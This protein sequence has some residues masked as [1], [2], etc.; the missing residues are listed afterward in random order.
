MTN[1]ELWQEASAANREC[2]DGKLSLSDMLAIIHD[3][4]VKMNENTSR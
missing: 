1:S 4:T 3:L 2:I